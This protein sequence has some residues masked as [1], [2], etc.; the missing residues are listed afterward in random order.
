MGRRITY[1]TAI[2]L[3][4]SACIA[5]DGLLEP[6]ELGVKANE[7]TAS[8]TGGTFTLDVMSD[9]DFTISLPDNAGWLSFE[10]I[11]GRSMNGHGDMSVN[12]TCEPNRG[13]GRH[14]V[15]TLTRGRRSVEVKFIQDGLISGGIEFV[16]RSMT[17]SAAAGTH[18]AR[19]MTVINDSDLHYEVISDDGSEWIRNLSKNN[20]YLS[21]SVEVNSSETESR[22]AYIK[23]SRRDEPSVNDVLTITQ[24]GASMKFEPVTFAEL[25]SLQ[26]D[27]P[28]SGSLVLEGTVISDNSE[29]N[30]GPNMNLSASLQDNS[31]AFRTVYIQAKDGSAGIKLIFDSVQD[32]ILRRFDSVRILLDGLT[33]TR[34]TDPQH[35]VFSGA[36]AANVISS[37]SGS[38][39]DVV[40]KERYI[41]ELTDSDIYTFVTLKDCEIP[42][43]KGPF[44]PIDIRHIYVINKY[45]MPIRDI[46]GSSMHLVTNFTA[47][48]QRDGNGLPE[49]S[50]DISGVIVHETCDNFNWDT[51]EFARRCEKGTHSDYIT[52][53]GKIGDYQIRP[54]TRDEIALAEEFEDGFS[55]LLIEMR[56]YNKSKSALV[57]NVDGNTMYSTYPPVENPLDPACEEIKG[58]FEPIASTGAIAGLTYYRDWTHLGPMEDGIITDP[59][60]GN[61]VYDYYGNSAHWSIYSAVSTTAL[62]L[63]ENGSAWACSQWSVA[64]Y[65]KAQFTTEGL[66]ESNFPLSVQFGAVSG[67]GEEVGAPRYWILE[68]SVDEGTS[69]EYVD[70]YTVPDFPIL[71]NRKPWQCPGPKYM[72][73]TLPHDSRLL[74]NSK[75]MVRMHPKNTSAGTPESYDGGII[76]KEIKSQ[77]NY[78]AIRYNK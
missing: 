7:I 76:D 63:E 6:E 1:L 31:L 9:G 23:V 70:E 30:G 67:L 57:R 21:F 10:G 75:V 2:L 74:D 29:G 42:F 52:E 78:F 17:V 5:K 15:L 14:T 51:E 43:R 47:A 44:F 20:N 25:T 55:E 39:Y 38:I 33:L 73:F 62:L 35:H 66:T 58:I 68:Y 65:W 61:G 59:A 72:T 3:M 18:S 8:C 24:L 22:R 34:Y 28:L 26:T 53:I 48:W 41:A 60:G 46:H 50:G 19:I 36:T 64:K 37:I 11:S 71:S 16:Q 40:P 27:V 77:I 4:T 13:I 12:V 56:Y 69:W 32:N 54:I 49:G 45:P